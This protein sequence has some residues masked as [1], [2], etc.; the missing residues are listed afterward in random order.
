LLKCRLV[1][2]RPGTIALQKRPK[3]NDI[4]QLISERL[5]PR[6]TRPVQYVGL[7]VNAR[8]KDVHSAEI[9]VA[10]GYADTYAIGISHL[11]TEIL[12]Q[13]LNDMPGVACD[14]T[15][16]PRKDAE[17]V[18]REFSIPLFG[19]ESRCALN[20]FD[21]IG[22]SL[23]YEMCAT[24]VLTMLDLA[25]VPIRSDRRDD[26]DPIIIAGDATADA[27]E[28]M[29]PFIDLFIVG[30]GEEPLREL[31]KLVR[32]AK[33]TDASRAE[34][35][36]QAAR[37][38]P[39]V[40]VP[41]L[42]RCDYS[43]DG[44]LNGLEPTE[45]GIPRQIV[46]ASLASLSESPQ[47]TRPLVAIAEPVHQRVVIEIMR[48]CP[49]ACRFCQA[50]ATRIPVRTRGVEEI[51]SIAR[52][53][54]ASTGYREIALLSL[55]S[56]DYPHLGELIERL[57][58]EFAERHVS[59]SLPSLRVD[60]QLR[61]LPRLTSHVRK[62]GLTIAAEAA[63]QRLRKAMRK[64]IA[65][66]DML[67]GVRAAYEAGWRRVKV[68]FITGLPGETDSEVDAIFDLCSRLSEIG[69]ETLNRPGAVSASVSWFVP[70][71][72]TP[73]QWAPM[74]EMDYYFNV[75]RRLKHLARRSNVHFRF[76]R[77]ERSFLEGV[78]ARGDRRIADVIETA[79]RSGARMDAWNEH[80]DYDKWTNAFHQNG[81]DPCFY[82]NHEIPT[83]EFT[84][85]SHIQSPRGR[86]FLLSEYEQ[87]EQDLTS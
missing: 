5:L 6:V 81:V 60:T 79:W 29:S 83:D 4:G 13:M 41:A 23:P 28:P 47:I 12:Y 16:C 72:H 51:V 35:L 64:Q 85:W 55:S 84:P 49:N 25:G 63:S 67:N 8:R 44:K 39:S 2:T 56:S 24:N 59:I 10:L 80:F 68:Y 76:H 32:D 62:A 42:Y 86:D 87:M 74:R 7:E 66:H 70:K 18:M 36:L 20:G 52:Q 48:G 69:R 30:D 17:V 38:I 31:V 53:A 61:Q 33:K 43:T 26:G 27:P 75:R 73:M 40:Y 21:I 11:G 19:W 15:Y 45:P 58:C 22:F 71:P 9:T 57:N 78:I 77:I 37:R 46:R 3:M 65:E 50:G 1:G 14:R 34:M 54:L 82:A